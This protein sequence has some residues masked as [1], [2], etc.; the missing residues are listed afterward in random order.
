MIQIKNVFRIIRLIKKFFIFLF[1]CF[2]IKFVFIKFCFFVNAIN[3]FWCLIITFNVFFTRIKISFL[4]FAYW[5]FCFWFVCQ[6]VCN[7]FLRTWH[8][9]A[10]FFSCSS[11]LNNFFFVKILADKNF[12]TIVQLLNYLIL[13]NKWIVLFEILCQKRF[14]K[15]E[16]FTS[17][18]VLFFLIHCESF[19]KCFQFVYNNFLRLSIIFLK[20]LQWD[21]LSN[22]W[23]YLQN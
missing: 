13:M 18:I 15:V 4:R 10:F 23:I 12:C 2:S 9:V 17:L 20:F 8:D 21:F 1:V 19:Q 5:D 14:F 6:F 16:F 3:R 22:H 11:L 7:L